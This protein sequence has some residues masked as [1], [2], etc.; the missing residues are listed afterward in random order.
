VVQSV[1]N[2]PVDT[3]QAIVGKISWLVCVQFLRSKD[4]QI[5]EL[6]HKEPNQSASSCA[7]SKRLSTP[8][9]SFRIYRTSPA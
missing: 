6:K 1:S 2:L 4:N 7:A 9:P 8:L 5:D 3:L